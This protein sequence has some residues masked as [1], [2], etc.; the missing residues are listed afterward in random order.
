MRRLNAYVF[1][2]PLLQ[3]GINLKYKLKNN[4]LEIDYPPFYR[5]AKSFIVKA[6]Y[7]Q[8]DIKRNNTTKENRYNNFVLANEIFIQSKK[9]LKEKYPEAKFVIL[10]YE[11][12]EDDKDNLELP[13]MWDVLEKE[14]F[15]IINSSDLVGRKFNYFSQDT[16]EDNYHPSEYAWDLL[17][18]DLIKTLKI[19]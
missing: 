10:R 9:I 2:D 14:G 11:T 5:F 19:K 12:V 4:S 15:I 6:F 8:F 3:N 1:P 18:P 16:T 17:I 7:Y 13:F